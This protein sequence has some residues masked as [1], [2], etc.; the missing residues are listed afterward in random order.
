[1]LHQIRF[2]ADVRRFFQSLKASGST[3]DETENQR[4]KFFKGLKNEKPNESAA[5]VSDTEREET[6]KVEA[7]RFSLCSL[8]DFQNT[9]RD[10]A[11]LHQPNPKESDRRCRKRPNYDTR[12]RAFY[13]KGRPKAH[14]R[15]LVCISLNSLFSFVCLCMSI[16]NMMCFAISFFDSQG[17]QIQSES[18]A[19]NRRSVAAIESN[20]INK[21]SDLTFSVSCRSFG[22]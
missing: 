17:S 9:M 3:S 19:W 1:M 21:S 20:V 22:L 15:L 12:K 13:A 11:D 5:T 16:C 18:D 7:V 8:L 10:H 14:D 4:K 2:C 6:K